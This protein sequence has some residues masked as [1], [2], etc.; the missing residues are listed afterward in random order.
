MGANSMVFR[1]L[2]A[3][4]HRLRVELVRRLSPAT[5]PARLVAD[6]RLRVLARPP[7]ATERAIAPE[8]DGP[9]P[10]TNRVPFTFRNDHPELLTSGH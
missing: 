2:P 7:N 5:P 9:P 1:P 4:L 10:P 3:G 8:E 6:Y